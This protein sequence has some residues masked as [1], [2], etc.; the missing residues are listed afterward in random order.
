MCLWSFGIKPKILFRAVLKNPKTKC[1]LNHKCE[2]VCKHIIITSQKDCRN[3]SYNPLP[4]SCR[5]LNEHSSHTKRAAFDTRAPYVRQSLIRP[6]A[7]VRYSQEI[8][9]FLLPTTEQS[10]PSGQVP[11]PCRTNPATRLPFQ[12]DS[13]RCVTAGN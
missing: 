2:H 11:N 9:H 1:L 4:N 7:G 10:P 5:E 12:H 8:I 6:S 13:N 3:L